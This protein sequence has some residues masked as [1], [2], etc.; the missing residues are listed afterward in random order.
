MLMVFF[1]GYKQ[2]FDK[3]AGKEADFEDEARQWIPG[4]SSDEDGYSCTTDHHSETVSA[5][6]LQ[7]RAISFDLED[8]KEYGSSGGRET[9]NHISR[10]CATDSLEAD[11]TSR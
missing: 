10:H 11:S 5:Y 6:E 2:G 9:S 7:E 4:H 8:N 1:F 3:K